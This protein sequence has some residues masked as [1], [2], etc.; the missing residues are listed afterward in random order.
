M[1]RLRFDYQP[2]SPLLELPVLFGLFLVTVLLLLAV[3]QK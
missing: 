3:F 1:R 2:P